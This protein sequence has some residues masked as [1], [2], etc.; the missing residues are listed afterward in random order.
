M[1]GPG[2]ERGPGP[3]T[4]G[5]QRQRQGPSRR[6]GG[7]QGHPGT[8]G[9]REERAPAAGPGSRRPHQDDA[10]AAGVAATR[11]GPAGG[12]PTRR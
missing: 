8:Q 1:Q 12:R 10:A 6:P 5:R 7:H 11:R 3:H 9:R 4:D 2:S